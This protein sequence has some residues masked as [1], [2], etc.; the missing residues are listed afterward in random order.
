MIETLT[1]AL[2]ACIPYLVYLA[3]GYI[4]REK[5]LVREAFFNDLNTFV[6]KAFFPFLMINSFYHIDTSKSFDHRFWF[7]CLFAVIGTILVLCAAVPHIVKDHSKI[8]T[9]IQALFRSNYLLFGVPMAEALFGQEGTELGSVI[10]A[11]V[12]PTYN[13]AS[14]IILEVFRGGKV[15]AKQLVYNVLTTPLVVGALIGAAFLLTGIPLPECLLLPI[16]KLAALSTPIAIVTLGGTLHFNAIGKNMRYIV[17]TLLFK[18]GIL[19][20][21]MVMLSVA[22]GFNELERFITLI[23]FA[24]PVAA[25]S[26]PMARNLGGDG[27]LAGQFVV[28]S[29]VLAIGTMFVWIVVLRTI[30]VI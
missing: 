27:E 12:I 13:V 20:L 15:S 14:V 24:T 26:Y 5:K 23:L 3:I 2:N 22:L 25:A 17:P 18:M 1:L 30:G 16:G 6:F 7:F 4:G 9:I 21:L 28:I 19:P 11:I 10:L 8:S 29:T